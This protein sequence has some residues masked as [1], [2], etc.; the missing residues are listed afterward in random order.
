[1]SQNERISDTMPK[2]L[3]YSFIGITAYNDSENFVFSCTFSPT[4]T[5]HMMN[6]DN[7]SREV[8][9]QNHEKKESCYALG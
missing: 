2:A 1:M 9:T 4:I 6:Q 8:I 7:N 5:G 3:M